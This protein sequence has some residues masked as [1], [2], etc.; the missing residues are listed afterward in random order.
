M[1]KFLAGAIAMASLGLSMQAN[2]LNIL[3]TNDDGCRAPGIDAMYRAL[4]AAGHKVTLVGPLND[5]SG[6][7]A[8]S[9]VVPGQALAVTELAP[10]KFCV[11]PPDGYSA[12]AGK[13]SAIGT[14]V[15]AV[16]VGL[17]VILK[18]NPPDLVVSGSNFG[19][20]VGPLTQMSGTL[21][22]ALRAMFKGIPAVAVSTAIDM[23]LIVRDQQAGFRKTLGAMDDTARFAVKVIEQ[24]SL[25]G[26]EARKACVSNKHACELNVLGLPG[27]NGLNLNYPPLPP[28]EVNGVVFA[29]I[30]NWDRVNFTSQRGAD[31]VVHVNLSAPSTPTA[32]QQ[33]ADAYQLWQGHAVI[34]VIDGNMSAPQA[35][36]DQAKKILKSIKP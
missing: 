8:A 29:P 3:L 13:T 33:Q 25:A 2:A 12:P 30:G 11:G 19:E 36:Q 14:P 17:D 6:I 7:S 31:G 34:T 10:G 26:A 21:N 24:A 23:D 16:N 28:S 15:D 5:S 20:N 27:V 1:N 22:A 18:D 32:T 35:V 4:T 9:V